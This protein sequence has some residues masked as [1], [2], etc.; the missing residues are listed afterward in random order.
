[1]KQACESNFPFKLTVLGSNPLTSVLFVDYK[2][3]CS[4]YP[5]RVNAPRA[6][7]STHGHDALAAEEL[8]DLL[9]INTLENSQ[10]W[11]TRLPGKYE[12]K[13]GDVTPEMNLN[14]CMSLYHKQVNSLATRH[15]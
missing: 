6:L 4:K 12:F 5:I 10:N 13:F 11:K 7:N 14:Q 8:D 1:M 2:V 9:W 3:G 15:I